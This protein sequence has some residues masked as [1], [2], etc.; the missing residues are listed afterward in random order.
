MKHRWLVTTASA[1]LLFGPLT[2]TALAATSTSSTSKAPKAPVHSAFYNTEIDLNG[3]KVCAPKG[4]AYQGTAYMPI[5]YVDQGLKKLGLQQSWDGKNWR[6]TTPSSLKPDLSNLK[7]G[8]SSMG[9]YINGTLVQTV[10]GI[11]DKDPSSG[12]VTTYMPIWYVMQA[13]KRASVNSSWDGKKWG[14]TSKPVTPTPPVYPPTP[15]NEVGKDTF[16][17][18]FLT[19]LGIQPDSSGNS[20]FDDVATTDDAWGYIQAAIENHIIQPDNATHFGMTDAVTMGMVDQMYWNEKGIGHADYEPGGA[21]YPWASVIG[22]NLSGLSESQPIAPTDVARIESNLMTLERGYTQDSSGTYH[23]VYPVGDE[24]NSTFPSSYDAQQA[25]TQAYEFFNQ[26]TVNVQGGNDVVSLPSTLNSQ[27][28]VYATTT[29]D[30]QYSLDNG[31]SWVSTSAFDTR[32]L[33]GQSAAGGNILVKA[34][35]TDGVAISYNELMPSAHGTTSL[36]EVVLSA[37]MSGLAVNRGI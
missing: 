15:A 16:V 20:P 33:A 8:K 19:T 10:N 29:N 7:P 9:I 37:G 4:F 26:V 18:D 25:S 23:V 35:A 21:P 3:L 34:D 31:G 6:L 27:W 22:L 32:N 17:Q 5:Y 13:L 28:F 12:A 1:T 14:V 24:Y 36:G 30:I 2:T 11:Y